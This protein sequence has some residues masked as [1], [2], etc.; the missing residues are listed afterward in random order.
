MRAEQGETIMTTNAD[1]GDQRSLA[2]RLARQENDPSLRI[3]PGVWF[4]KGTPIMLLTLSVAT[5][6][7]WMF[8]DFFSG[9]LT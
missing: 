4:R 9:P 2:E 5:L 1:Q 3:T 8:W 7:I 6:L